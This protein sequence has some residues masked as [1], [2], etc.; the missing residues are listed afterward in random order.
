MLVPRRRSFTNLVASA[1]F[2]AVLHT[3]PDL[4][5]TFTLQLKDLFPRL[6]VSHTL[7]NLFLMFPLHRKARV[8]S[9]SYLPSLLISWNLSFA[10][11]SLNCTYCHSQKA[12]AEWITWQWGEGHTLNHKV[13]VMLNNTVRER[14]DITASCSLG[15]V[16]HVR[17]GLGQSVHSVLIKIDGDAVW[18]FLVEQAP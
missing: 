1:F 14:R 9:L 15:R 3:M 6:P 12:A 18:V 7:S 17:E 11:F 2:P 16:N 4:L 8:R 5:F 13:L 10:S